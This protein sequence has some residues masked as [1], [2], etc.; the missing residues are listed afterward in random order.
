MFMN[1]LSSRSPNTDDQPPEFQIDD[2]YSVPG[3]DISA[4][5]Y[6]SDFIISFNLYKLLLRLQKLFL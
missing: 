1:L 2:T 6:D 3:I 5:L 4:I